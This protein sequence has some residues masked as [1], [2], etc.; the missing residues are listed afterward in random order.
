[1]APLFSVDGS[2][3]LEGLRTLQAFFRERGGLE[4]DA[5]IDPATFVDASFITAATESLG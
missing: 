2:L 5:D 3:D 4:Y 1:V